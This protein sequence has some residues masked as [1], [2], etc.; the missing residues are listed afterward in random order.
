MGIRQPVQALNMPLIAIAKI[1][2]RIR[3]SSL[4]V[5]RHPGAHQP[6]RVQRKI[7]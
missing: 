3:V 5:L 6:L 7:F 4:I 2:L 1:I